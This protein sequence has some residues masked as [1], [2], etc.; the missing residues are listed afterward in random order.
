MQLEGMRSTALHEDYTNFSE[1]VS[2][3]KDQDRE[4][5]DSCYPFIHMET[6]YCYCYYPLLLVY[7][8]YSEPHP[9]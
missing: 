3:Q 2:P 8:D 6:T 7:M 9:L 4:H 5:F 1:A